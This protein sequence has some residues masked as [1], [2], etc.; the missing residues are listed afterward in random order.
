MVVSSPLI[1]N[2]TDGVCPVDVLDTIPIP[3]PEINNH[4]DRKIMLVSSSQINNHIENVCLVDVHDTIPR[5][6]P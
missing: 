2:H 1:N 5:P 3:Y 6:Y 4:W